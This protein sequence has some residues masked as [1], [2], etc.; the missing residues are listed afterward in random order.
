MPNIGFPEILLI[1]VIAV[2]IFG[3]NRLPQIGEG[4]GKAIK[5]FKRGL[6]SEDEIKI[7]PADKQVSADT[8]AE[9]VRD[10]IAAPEDAH[11][12]SKKPGPPDNV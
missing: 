12:V 3:A 7:R 6:Q 8:R 1:L 2:L 11:V 9:R 5:N 4:F 10:S